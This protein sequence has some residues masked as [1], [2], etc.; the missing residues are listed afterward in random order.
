MPLVRECSENSITMKKHFFSL[1]TVAIVIFPLW[2]QSS[3]SFFRQADSLYAI[4]IDSY[5]QGNYKV[6]IKFFL[7]CD[8]LNKA[9]E[10]PEPYY[11][12]NAAQWAGS[13]F[14]K[15]G[16]TIQAKKLDSLY[17][18]L[19]PVDGRLTVI[20]DSLAFIA[21]QYKEK[22]DWEKALKYME[23]CAEDAKKTLG[24]KHYYY[25]NIL[26][27]IAFCNKNLGK[28]N[29]AILV[30]TQALYIWTE[31]GIFNKSIKVVSDNIM[32]LSLNLAKNLLGEQSPDYMKLLNEAITY[33]STLG[34]YNKTIELETELLNI[35]KSILINQDTDNDGLLNE[36]ANYFFDIGDYYS[37]QGYH[38]KA[39]SI[40]KVA[41]KIKKKLY[42]KYNDYAL[43]LSNLA[44]YYSGLGNNNKSI[45]LEVEALN[46]RKEVLGEQ[47]P[48]YASS[49]NNLAVYYSNIGDYSKS[50][51][52]GMKALNI[53]KEVLGEQH[54]DYVSSLNNLAIY[55]S[56][57]GDYT[58]SIEL[59]TQVLHIR[60]EVLGVQHPDYASSLSNL[61]T[62]YSSLENNVKSIELETQALHI[63]KEVLGV[64]HPDYASSLSNLAT[65]YSSLGNNVKSIELETQAFNIK[66]DRLGNRH[67]DYAF[68]LDNLAVYYSNFGWYNEAV[69]LTIEALNIKK[70]IVGI[71][72]PTYAT[73]L[74]NLANYY[75]DL[76]DNEKALKL[77]KHALNIRKEVFGEHHPD[78]MASLYNLAN[79]YY[80][81]SNWGDY[82][83]NYGNFLKI[84]TEN[85]RMNFQNLT[86]V[87]RNLYW[88]GKKGPLTNAIIY[89]I[90]CPDSISSFYEIAYDA[91]L[92]SKGIL[93]SSEI[94]FN[95][96]IQESGD[97]VLLRKFEE[98][99]R[100][101]LQL[102]A[103][104]QKPITERPTE[105]VKQLETRADALEKD[106]IKG[107]KE[108]GDFTKR[109]T[110]KWQDVQAAL[111][112]RDI[113]VE[114]AVAENDSLRRH[115]ALLLR[116]D[117]KS[118]KYVY[119]GAE[120]ELNAY[121]HQE[122]DLYYSQEL[123]NKIWAKIIKVGEVKEGENIWFSPD[124]MLYRLGVEY[125]PA[126]G[127]RK[128]NEKYHIRRLS[129]T[130]ELCFADEKQQVPSAVLYGGLKYDLSPKEQKKE[131]EK[132]KPTGAVNRGDEMVGRLLAAAT[133]SLLRND[134]KDLPGTLT[135]VRNI[136]ATLNE[137]HVQNDT[138]I[139]E[140]GN[141]ESV[142]AL[143]GKAPRMLHIATHG[144]YLQPTEAEIR[145]QQRQF[146]LLMQGDD[147]KNR[148]I[149]YSMSRTG[150][151]FAGAKAAWDGQPVPENVDDG[152]MTA[153]EISQLDFRGVD[154][155][156]LSACQTGLGDITSDGV[157]GLQR[158]FKKAGVKTL[159]MSLWKVDDDATQLMMT[160]FY[161][162]LAAGQRKHDAFNNALTYLRNYEEWVEEEVEDT[163]Q[164][165]IFDG[166]LGMY[167]Y[168]KKRVR[169]LR[170][171]YAAPQ[172]WAAF[173]MLD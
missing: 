92:L 164:E 57:L 76:G 144:F 85:L 146:S 20:S 24:E 109:L 5:N 138:F 157:A 123:S 171:I 21:K 127:E 94:E 106:L 110:I 65:Y 148:V 15:L 103:W 107:S 30:W 63:R 52:L 99:R 31:A 132:Q 113:A 62:Y 69:E 33:Y 59:G 22:E 116:K 32:P 104:Y 19:L 165:Q 133:D 53:R 129:S 64:Q 13:A 29:E 168:P 136:A 84:F 4:G 41:L 67:P 162:N 131:S 154:L 40:G 167:V 112:E 128:M 68:S 39:V 111:G 91:V 46:I 119:I 42:K 159:V 117:W 79:Y 10:R 6:A 66:S 82:I 105:E 51:V 147:R 88:E 50:V 1:F 95:K 166:A 161:E 89:S 97:T 54:P 118:P 74:N 108:F 87:Q 156:V 142:K 160:C 11:S 121:L 152:I 145:S 35:K 93:L 78:F 36:L 90:A 23:E 70:E 7:F 8:S 115:I 81:K 17:F 16:D 96:V 139:A 170:K 2:G 73:S 83:Q 169:E 163:E 86:A 140:R 102:D 34:E 77:G 135:E 3:Q 43:S 71:K 101:R 134:I 143:S 173:I 158:G 38:N 150:L 126:G 28:T 151:L 114:F 141:E 9:T 44:T 61:A 55:Y 48:D 72:H 80:N 18:R 149:D 25:A 58:K 124:G 75:S 137:K 60:K 47:H 56:N 27:L 172:Y 125:L 49:L 120:Q 14:Y 37:D 100:A 12:E 155:A 153:K 26:D 45:E 130:K 122:T 98:M